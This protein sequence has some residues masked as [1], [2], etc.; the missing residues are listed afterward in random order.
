[1]E[2]LP[3]IVGI[4][5]AIFL[6]L[7]AVIAWGTGLF[8]LYA[9]ESFG[10]PLGI[11]GVCW[12]F[13]LLIRYLLPPR[14]FEIIAIK[15]VICF[16]VCIQVIRSALNRCGSVR[17]TPSSEFQ[18]D[19]REI[20]PTSLLEGALMWSLLVSWILVHEGFGWQ[21]D[22]VQ[23]PA[24]AMSLAAGVVGVLFISRLLWK[25][26]SRISRTRGE[27]GRKPDESSGQ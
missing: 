8:R 10:T 9:L 7:W 24:W 23:R 21:Y 17:E 2:L 22:R 5:L 6:L 11:G 27:S 13:S 4:D 20:L 19:A 12:S 3:L 16:I 26:A 1:M 15:T 14:D 25:S 18:P